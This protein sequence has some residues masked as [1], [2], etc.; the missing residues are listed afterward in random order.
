MYVA[1]QHLIKFKHL[2]VFCV[3]LFQALKA[4]KDHFEAVSLAF[5]NLST[6]LRALGFFGH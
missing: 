6:A 2:G 1:I 5:L 4:L 3:V